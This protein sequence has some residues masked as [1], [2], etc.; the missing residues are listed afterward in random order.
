[1]EHAMA[2]ETAAEA[3][4]AAEA[5]EADEAR[6]KEKEAQEKEAREKE[7]DEG[8]AMLLLRTLMAAVDTALAAQILY[9][10]IDRLLSGNPIGALSPALTP[11][12]LDALDARN[13]TL[14]DFIAR[15]RAK[16]GRIVLLDPAVQNGHRTCHIVQAPEHI[17]ANLLRAASLLDLVI[18]QIVTEKP[19]RFASGVPVPDPNAKPPIAPITITI[20]GGTVITGNVTDASGNWTA[21]IPA[22]NNLGTYTITVSGGQTTGS[23]TVTVAASGGGGGLPVTGSSNSLPLT[24]TGAALVAAG[25]LVVF[26]VRRSASKNVREDVTV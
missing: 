14:E 8:H 1:M 13:F 4:E 24:Q 22:P 21:S 12:K 17:R 26:G 10:L 23:T 5:R 15:A 20:S 3:A 7:A 11:A 9:K 18:R 19:M 16:S 6:E 25:A 2:R